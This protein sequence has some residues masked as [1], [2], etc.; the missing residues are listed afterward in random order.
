MGALDALKGLKADAKSRAATAEDVAAAFVARFPND[1]P[2]AKAMFAKAVMDSEYL[3]RQ[4]VA[5]ALIRS[6]AEQWFARFYREMPKGEGAARDDLPLGHFR[7]A[8]PDKISAGGLQGR[9]QEGHLPIANRA[10]PNDDGGLAVSAH[11]GQN[12]RA[13]VVTPKLSGGQASSASPANSGL[14]LA[15]PQSAVDIAASAKAAKL[16]AETVYERIKMRDGRA[17]G[18]IRYSE[19][20]RYRSADLASAAILDRVKLHAQPPPGTDPKVKDLISAET[21]EAFEGRRNAA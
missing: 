20:D 15:R 9:A 1:L 18:D 16:I 10:E 3:A 4:V 7:S 2:R 6:Q 13:A 14:P 17:I 11:L 12:K 19:I 8:A 21:L 5:P